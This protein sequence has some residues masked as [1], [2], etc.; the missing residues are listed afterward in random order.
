[1]STFLDRLKK[2]D[3]V[4]TTPED[5]KKAQVATQATQSAQS[6]LYYL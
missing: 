2:K 5:A 1:M 3:L 6:N 4:P